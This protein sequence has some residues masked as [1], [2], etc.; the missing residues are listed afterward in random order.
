M[1]RV[2]EKKEKKR[3]ALED[4]AYKLF[5]EK[6]LVNT[7]ISDIVEEAGVA[8]GTFYLY[9]EDKYDVAAQLVYIVTGRIFSNAM[10][11]LSKTKILTPEDEMVMISDHI[12]KQ[13][14][15]EP[16]LLQYFS[17]AVNWE[18]FKESVNIHRMDGE[19]SF[20]MIFQDMK[21]R[22]FKYDLI[23]PEVMV[24]LILEFMLS[25]CYSPIVSQ[26]PMPIEQIKPY[27]LNVIREIVK[28]HKGCRTF[29]G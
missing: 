5:C 19:Y 13:L 20:N 18:K 10:E 16:T 8:K 7:S 24:F 4:A 29:N 2:N 3:R 22:Y 17:K 11:A 21:V 6:G 1:G 27:V 25:A 15:E 14:V 12:I 28:Q 26:Q 9:Y 23:E